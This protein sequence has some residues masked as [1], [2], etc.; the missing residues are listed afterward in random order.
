MAENAY[1]LGAGRD[2][3]EI[4]A[5]TAAIPAADTGVSLVAP[6][7]HVRIRNNSTGTTILY[8]ALD[9]TTA[10]AADFTVGPGKDLV[11]DGPAIKD[12]RIFGSAAA[13][14]YSV[15]AW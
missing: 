12:F 9:N 5:I 11:Y 7:Q 2:Q 14:T 13:D 4:T 6:S 15:L 10:S 1:L 3:N 8:V